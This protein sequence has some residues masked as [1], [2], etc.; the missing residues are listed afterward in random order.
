MG[1]I[2]SLKDSIAAGLSFVSSTLDGNVKEL[3]IYL[4]DLNS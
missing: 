1:A 4:V 2:K 3:S